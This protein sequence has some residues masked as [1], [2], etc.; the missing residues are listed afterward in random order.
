MAENNTAANKQP[1]TAASTELTSQNATA[2]RRAGENITTQVLERVAAKQKAGELV[3]PKGYEAGNALNSAWLYLQTIE[4]KTHQ[5]A[6]DVCTKNSIANALLQMVIKGEH[7][8]THCYFIPCG[9]SLEFWERYTGK[10]MRA[11][12]DTNI[13][14][15]HAQVIYDGD[16]FVYTVDENGDYQLVKHETSIDNMDINKIK[17]AYAVVV[18]KDGSRHLE[19]MTIDMIRK[20]WGQGAARGNSGAHTNFTDQMCKKTIISRACK[21]ALDSTSDGE[22]EDTM[23]P[24]TAGQERDIANDTAEDPIHEA[25]HDDFEDG[26]E[27]EDVT[28]GSEEVQDAQPDAAPMQPKAAPGKKVREC[29]I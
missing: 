3:L 28:T 4:T 24:P 26:A 10:L 20:A 25:H 23:V 18:N 29:P 5:K 16:N 21:V 9:N 22:E 6:I 12:R 15:V 13:Q 7:C 14:S 8:G 27:Y 11:K 17:G 2:I 1:A 19:I